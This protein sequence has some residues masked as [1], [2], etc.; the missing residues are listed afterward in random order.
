MYPVKSL[1]K[2]RK[3]SFYTGVMTLK[4]VAQI[5]IGQIEHKIPI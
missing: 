3:V 2:Y 5:K 4:N 1:M